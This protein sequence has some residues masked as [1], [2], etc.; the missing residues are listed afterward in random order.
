[1]NRL[2]FITLPTAAAAMALAL[3]FALFSQ[4]LAVPAVAASSNHTSM[5]HVA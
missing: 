2:N 4:T 1:M 3:S 5:E